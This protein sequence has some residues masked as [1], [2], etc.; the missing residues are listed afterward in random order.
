MLARLLKTI[1]IPVEVAIHDDPAQRSDHWRMLAPTTLETMLEEYRSIHRFILGRELSKQQDDPFGTASTAWDLLNHPRLDPWELVP[2]ICSL[3]V[4]QIGDVP[5]N[6]LLD[7][8]GLDN[9]APA[10]IPS[11]FVSW[12]LRMSAAHA[13]RNATQVSAFLDWNALRKKFPNV[14]IVIFSDESGLDWFLKTFQSN[15]EILNE[16]S[17]GTTLLQPSKGFLRGSKDLLFSQ[18]H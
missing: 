2:T 3:I 11:N 1:D 16:L 7:K 6:F 9:S 5:G 10:G 17:A 18:F 8:R 4:V 12:H 13:D 15:P 14:P